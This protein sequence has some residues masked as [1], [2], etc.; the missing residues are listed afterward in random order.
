MEAM[1]NVRLVLNKFYGTISVVSGTGETVSSDGKT[2][3]S[4]VLKKYEKGILIGRDCCE[5]AR[6]LV[7][8]FHSFDC[9]NTNITDVF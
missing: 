8:M 7:K 1:S 5:A 4:T 9:K 6:P 3:E 2:C